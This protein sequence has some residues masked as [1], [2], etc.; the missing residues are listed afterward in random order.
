MRGEAHAMHCGSLT[1]ENRDPHSEHTLQVVRGARPRWCRQSGN[2]SPHATQEVHWRAVGTHYGPTRK[3]QA[4]CS[5]TPSEGRQSWH[6]DTLHRRILR[7]DYG[8][9]GSAVGLCRSTPRH[10][11]NWTTRP[12][13]S[14]PTRR[15][16]ALDSKLSYYM[17]TDRQGMGRV[18]P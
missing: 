1:R 6:C 7:R 16:D 15:P 3:H 12:S 10:A 11:D 14:G 13:G 17:P 5:P 4:G 18:L 2:S 9:D 8:P